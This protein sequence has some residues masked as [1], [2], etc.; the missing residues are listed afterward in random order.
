MTYRRLDC[1]RALRR[2]ERIGRPERG[3]PA[4]G[5][6]PATP[7]PLRP[8]AQ[9][10]RVGAPL[11]PFRALVESALAASLS[12][13]LGLDLDNVR[14]RTS[15]PQ[16]VALGARAF[17]SG[18][19]IDFAP[20]AFDP[21]SAAG[22]RVIGHELAHVAQQRL[23]RVPE[24]EGIVADSALEREAD[25]AGELAATL[26][27][28][29]RMPGRPFYPA[30]VP[31]TAQRRAVQCLMGLAEFK[32]KSSALGPR[33][34]IRVI[35]KALDDFHALDKQKPRDYAKLVKALQ[36]LSGLG[37][38]Y[39]RQNA[40]SDR[41]AG[42]NKLMREIALEVAVLEPLAK[43]ASET[44]LISKWEYLEQA[45]EKLQELKANADFTRPHCDV[46]ITELITPLDGNTGLL[47]ASGNEA[48]LV[49]RDIGLLRQL[50]DS[51]DMPS[52]LKS[53]IQE[54][55]NP[56]NVWKLDLKL[57]APGANY[58]LSNGGDGPKY[59]LKHKLAHRGLK[60]RLGSL[61]HELTHISIAEIFNN[62]V[63]MLAIRRDA[64]DKE[65]MDL[66]RSRKAKLAHLGY[67][68]NQATDLGEL[69]GDLREQ[70]KYPIS[71]AQF[72]NYL[73]AF[74]PM[75]SESEYSRFAR[76]CKSDAG[77][78]L[79]LIEYD[80]VINQMTLWCA[81]SKFAQSHVVYKE[82]LALAE[83]AYVRRRTGRF[84]RLSLS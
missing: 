28:G 34:N 80:T 6:Q 35:D 60:W 41:T 61:L 25:A 17:A 19:Q 24:V 77:L 44:D 20:G 47:K 23:A 16:A 63:L 22:W 31:A 48:A 9:A 5:A 21:S 50:V 14:I 55:T 3:E 53:I 81:L 49:A 51:K 76:L 83:E 43:S 74:K 58:N 72:V 1:R 26:F 79:E 59:T 2:P 27:A 56:A 62:T 75:L 70:A 65:I 12:R 45:Q 38:T 13:C 30:P 82:L 73:A 78:S 37:D 29:G 32:A 8:L 84:H 15:S 66:A 39:L 42:V 52:I 18:D 7:P 69:Q 4:I 10:S 67:I 40:G 57:Y 68:I 54:A 71:S 36:A 46:E 11:L 64:D 33:N